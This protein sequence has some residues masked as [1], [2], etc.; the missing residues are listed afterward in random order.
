MVRMWC[1]IPAVATGG[2]PHVYRSNTAGV[3]EEHRTCRGQSPEEPCLRRA[4]SGGGDEYMDFDMSGNFC[5]FMNVLSW[6]MCYG[7]VSHEKAVWFSCL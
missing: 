3:P 5:I 7:V 6:T 1:G 2:V 4:C